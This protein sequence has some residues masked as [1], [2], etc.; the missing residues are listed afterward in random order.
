MLLTIEEITSEIIDKRWVTVKKLGGDFV[1][2]V[3]ELFQ[4][5]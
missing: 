4:Q 5:N 1:K 2:T 3:T